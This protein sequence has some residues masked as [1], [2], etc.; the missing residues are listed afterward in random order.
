MTTFT[1]AWCRSVRAGSDTTPASNDLMASAS[2]GPTAS[3][4]CWRRAG[5]LLQSSGVGAGS[6]VHLALTN[7]PAF[8]ALWLAAANLGAW[9]VPSDP[10]SS[11]PELVQHIER[12]RPA[13]GFCAAARAAL[14][15]PAAG[16][17][18]VVELDEADCE[19]EP[20]GLDAIET[21]PAPESGPCRRDVHERHDRSPKG[22]EITQAN[23]AFAGRRW[24]GPPIWRRGTANSSCCRCSTS[25]RSTTASRRRSGA[26]RRWP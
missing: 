3:L 22:V 24:R 6:P 23:Y 5:A 11:T 13:V 14:Y 26:E 12:T 20:F 19:L 1:E 15:R 21:W 10:M 9:I 8:V 16:D 25:T 7:S 2:H 18:P 17:M 4:T